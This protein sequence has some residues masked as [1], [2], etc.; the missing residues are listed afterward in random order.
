MQNLNLNNKWIVISFFSYLFIY[1]IIRSI[2]VNPYLD[3]LITLNDYIESNSN[4]FKNLGI[5][6]ANNHLLN[7]FL[8]KFMYQFFGPNFFYLR[9]PNLLSFII[10]FFS[11]KYIVKKTIDLPYQL[12]VFIALNTIAWIFEY[13]GFIRGYALAISFLFSSIVALN[14][15]IEKKKIH[16]FGLFLI[17]MLLFFSANL[18]FFYTLVLLTLFAVFHFSFQIKTLSKS[19]LI[20][21][22]FML[23]VFLS[24]VYPLII[25][26]FKL[27]EAGALWWGNL[28]GLWRC[29]GVSVVEITFFTNNNIFKYILLFF[30]LT[31]G[32]LGIIL[33]VKKGVKNY[34]FSLEG[35]FFI[36]LFGNFFIIEMLALLL[37]VNYPRDRAAMQ[38]VFFS[39][40]TFATIFQHFRYIK[41]LLLILLYFPISFIWKTNINSSIYQHK[42]RIS[43]IIHNYINNHIT[44]K[45][46]YSV[47]PLL[48]PS[49]NF[50]LRKKTDTPL[51]TTYNNDLDFV[52]PNFLITEDR[53]ITK[54]LPNYYKSIL[55]DKYSETSIYKDM[56]HFAYK[57][58][59]E[60]VIPYKLLENEYHNVI[61]YSNVK[62]LVNSEYFACKISCEINFIKNTSPLNMVIAMG[63]S[64]NYSRYYTPIIIDRIDI[65]K[66]TIKF[67]WK[68]PIYKSLPENPKLI[69]YFWD[70]Y[71]KQIKMKDFKFTLFKVEL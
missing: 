54:I 62:D 26:S 1:L 27:K 30:Y 21:Y 31:L 17:S 38:L 48:S 22:I 28:D 25:Y 55:Y 47:D 2:Y 64:L 50:A 69:V 32:I 16:F 41:Y 57:T 24:A 9:I 53:N 19:H 6:S 3:E 60:T 14:L 63:D 45:F 46:S 33:L 49:M 51:F 43:P 59:K 11:T 36:L 18:S 61:D 8:C 15:W 34:L 66:R 4:W 20:S 68:S 65:N 71:K 58:V 37:K 13:F 23:L 10:F 40:I 56:R 5:G 29:T 7:S 44:S 67:V 35:L 52:Q 12:L 42:L 70:V 39:I